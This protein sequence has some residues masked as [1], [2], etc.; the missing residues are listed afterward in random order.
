MVAGFAGVVYYLGKIYQ[1]LARP[2]YEGST[3]GTGT[4]G[5]PSRAGPAPLRREIDPWRS[6]TLATADGL[7][8]GSTKKD[9]EDEAA[10]CSYLYTQGRVKD[11]TGVELFGI[12]HCGETVIGIACPSEPLSTELT[13]ALEQDTRDVLNHWA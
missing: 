6:F 3:G 13:D 2:E 7:L 9:A 10:R 4:P 11:E 1:I 8:I 5:E 12:P